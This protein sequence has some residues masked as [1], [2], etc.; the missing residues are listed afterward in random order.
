MHCGLTV[1][2]RREFTGDKIK[3]YLAVKYKSGINKKLRVEG[4][5]ILKIIPPI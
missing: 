1:I 5:V 2:I 4:R 3:N